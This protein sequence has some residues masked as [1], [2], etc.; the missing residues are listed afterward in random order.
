MKK[1]DVLG[2]EFMGGGNAQRPRGVERAGNAKGS[3]RRPGPD[4]CI[5]AAGMEAHGRG[6]SYMYDR[7]KQALSLETDRPIALRQATMASAKGGV[8]SVISIYGGLV[9]KFPLRT[10]MNR[11]LTTGAASA[12][13]I[14][15]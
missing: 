7:T 5:D 2:H 8:V 1:G 12:T 9:D 10:I 3:D 4:S 13:C 11:S 15:T 6:L 14:A